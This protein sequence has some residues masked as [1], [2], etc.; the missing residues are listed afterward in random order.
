MAITKLGNA[1]L[2]Q[3]EKDS[4]YSAGYGREVVK[5]GLGA[6][7]LRNSVLSGDLTGRKT[8]YHGTDSESARSIRETGLRGG[9]E[10]NLAATE[11]LKNYSED[12]YRKSLGKAYATKFKSVAKG[13]AN[14]AAYKKNKLLEFLGKQPNLK[15]DVVELNVPTWK[16]K[17]IMNPEVNIPYDK[18]VDEGLAAAKRDHGV[19]LNKLQRQG[20]KALWYAPY[21]FLRSVDAF[22]GTVSP[23]YIKGSSKY[24]GNSIGEFGEYIG[25][26]PGRFLRGV[27]K[28]GVGVG[29]L[30]NGLYNLYDKYQNSK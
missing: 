19:K 5:S 11:Q 4:K 21:R 14:G 2:K 7:L 18:W 17:T 10:G 30:G 22:D 12:R 24:K 16:Q 13:Y 28:A 9:S 23:E 25:A 20:I 15:A 3:A 8:T 6:A 26:R 29:L 27:G 1:M